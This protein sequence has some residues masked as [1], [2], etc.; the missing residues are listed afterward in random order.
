[1]EVDVD[2]RAEVPPAVAASDLSV[3]YPAGRGRESFR[4]LSGLT[5]E[6]AAGT[7]LG[8]VGETGSGTTTFLKVLAGLADVK[9]GGPGVPQI[10][11]GDVTVLGTPLRRVSRRR[12]TRLSVA[13]GYLAQ[14]AGS[15]L[16][17]Q[18]TAGENIAEPIFSR[19]RHFDEREAGRRVYTLVDAVALPSSVIA[20]F[21]HELS[22]GQRQRVAIARSLVLGP[23]L[24]V[25]DEPTAGIDVFGREAV[26]DLLSGLQH[27]GGFSAVIGSA[28][29]A[30]ASRL[31]TRIVL[32]NHGAVVGLGSIDDLLTS[33]EHPYVAGLAAS[34]VEER[35]HG[36]GASI[37][38]TAG[39]AA[40]LDGGVDVQ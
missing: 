28:D 20:L 9:P 31:S 23:R 1:M 21:P 4:A 10:T 18:L 14:D 27:R 7:T 5:F 3:S 36:S 30:V 17:P 29:I 39:E 34:R 40:A 35:N 2:R 13:V 15:T 24:W 25:A 6:V 16:D 22:S 33:P 12:R 26:V 8:V 37:D 11:G 38:G 19:D 32:L